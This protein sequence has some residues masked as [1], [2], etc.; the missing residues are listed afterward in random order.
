MN[1]V[2]LSVFVGVCIATLLL[3]NCGFICSLGEQV[4]EKTKQDP[5]GTRYY[6]LCVG[7]SMY[8]TTPKHPVI[9]V[10]EKEEDYVVGDFVFAVLDEEQC[11]I[12]SSPS[13]FVTHR[14]VYEQNGYVLL[15]GDNNRYSE[16]YV[17]KDRIICNV[18]GYFDF[19][20]N[21]KCLRS[22]G[23]YGYKC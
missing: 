14:I 5:V 20:G 10:C 4:L 11:N 15:K 17:S 1:K 6:R 13:C 21:Y 22:E 3:N 16:G 9:C 7:E 19:G 18:V 23:I 12:F 8:P 2:V